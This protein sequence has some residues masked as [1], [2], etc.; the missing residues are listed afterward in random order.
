MTTRPT[1]PNEIS[2]GP[3]C[4]EVVGHETTF[5]TANP[6][7]YGYPRFHASLAAA[8]AYAKKCNHRVSVEVRPILKRIRWN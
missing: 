6:L 4:F 5:S 8:E 3:E 1:N 2:F 7:G